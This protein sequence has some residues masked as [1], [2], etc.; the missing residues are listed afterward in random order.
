VRLV[1]GL[2][3]LGGMFLMAWNVWKTAS[4]RAA[5]PRDALPQPA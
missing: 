2:L 3:V 4:E 5:Q 1:G